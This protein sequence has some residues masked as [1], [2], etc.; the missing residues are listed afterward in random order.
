M[1]KCGKQLEAPLGIFGG[2]FDPIH[3]GHIF[4][5]LEAA[6]ITSINKIA[7]TPCFVPSHKNAATASSQ[8]RLKMVKE[9]CKDYPIFYPE[10]LDINRNKP[11]YSL[12]TLSELRATFPNTPLCFFI[13][14]DSLLNIFQWNSWQNLFE[15]CHFI[16]CTR[17]SEAVNKQADSAK[18]Q[19]MLN[20]LLQ[21]RQV[22]DPINLHKTLA[23]HIY[24]AKTSPLNISSSAI[25]RMLTT[26]Q[27]VEKLVPTSVNQYLRQHK[28]YQQGSKL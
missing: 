15:M 11:T 7:L 17:N 1:A 9:V 24:M 6:K 25:R 28:L 5:T 20:N 22:K 12:D 27:S 18:N 23:G 16:V 13:G 2:T 26:N 14:T 8:Q 19:I 4:P 10:P 3:N 21:K